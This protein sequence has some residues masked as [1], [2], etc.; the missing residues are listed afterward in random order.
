[1]KEIRIPLYGMVQLT[2]LEWEIINSKPFQRLRRIKQLAFSDYIWVC[3][4]NVFEPHTDTIYAYSS[5]YITNILYVRWF[6]L[7]LCNTLIYPGAVH[8]RFEHSIGVMHLAT[9]AFDCICSKRE[10]RDLLQSKS[11]LAYNENTRERASQWFEYPLSLMILV[12]CHFRML[13]K[14]FCQ[15]KIMKNHINTKRIPMHS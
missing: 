4:T 1:M 8:T 11:G 12:T 13:P 15:N 5:H 3:C 14:E 7:C 9:Q 6:W 10:V 2:D